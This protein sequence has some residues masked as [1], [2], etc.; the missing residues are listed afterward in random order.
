M[1]WDVGNYTPGPQCE[2]FDF[3]L[4]SEGFERLRASTAETDGGGAVCSCGKAAADC[5]WPSCQKPEP[6]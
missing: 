6:N 2:P 5:V 4:L 1:A 3:A